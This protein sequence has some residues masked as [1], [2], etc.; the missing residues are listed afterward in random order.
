VK[1]FV[2]GLVLVLTFVAVGIAAAPP[3]TFTFSDPKAN[4]TAAETDT[5][6]INDAG[7]IAGDYVDGSGVQHAMI[8]AGSKL[9]T[10]NI[11]GC[12]TSP[13][14]TSVAFYNVNKTGTAAGWCLSSTTGLNA[15]FTWAK[16][17][18]TM[19]KFPKSNGTQ[20]NGINDNGDVVGSYLDSANVQHGFVRV[21]GKF[22][23]VDVKGDTLTNVW[24]INASGIATVEATNSSNV[25]DAYLYNTKTKKL[26]KKNVTGATQS[27]IH[28]IN[29]KGDIVYTYD[30]S[31]GKRHGGL[32]HGGKFFAVDDPK[33]TGTNGTRAD[34]V[35]DTLVI[36]GRYSPSDGSSHGF[37]AVTK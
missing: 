13:G 23:T 4:K 11:K 33:A 25:I 36:V 27:I 31:D 20:V 34:G 17:K 21:G 15:G 37:K 24:G 3:L 7:A 19:V 26:T 14:S 29:N 5:Y 6:G 1:R 28:S 10:V 18:T 9:T 22:S 12:T 35:N 30:T 32:F 16:G 2:Y 8:L